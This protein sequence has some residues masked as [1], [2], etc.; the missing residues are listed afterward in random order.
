[1]ANLPDGS[2][3]R[4]RSVLISLWNCSS[5]AMR[6]VAFDHR[7]RR[8]VQAGPPAFQL[9]LRFE[10]QLTI[11]IGGA[12]Y[13]GASRVGR[14]IQ[15]WCRR[16]SRTVCVHERL[17]FARAQLLPIVRRHGQPGVLIGRG[18]ATR[19]PFDQVVQ[20]AALVGKGLPLSFEKRQVRLGCRSHCLHAA[21]SGARSGLGRGAAPAPE[22]RCS[23]SW[24][25]AYR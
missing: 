13:P 21:E 16:G 6:L 15:S 17:A 8:L 10:Q 25:A 4:S 20:P 23:P 14:R 2:R 19:V 3:S 11:A 24:C 7:L 9:N 12:L 1:M 18:R 22:R 5:V